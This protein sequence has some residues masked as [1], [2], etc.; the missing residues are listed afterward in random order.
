MRCLVI[1]VLSA[2]IL[3]GIFISNPQGSGLYSIRR[4]APLIEPAATSLRPAEPPPRTQTSERGSMQIVQEITPLERDKPIERE[5][6]GGQSHS[7]RITM[8]SGQ[9]LQVAVDQR[10]VDVLVTLF[11]PDGE[12]RIEVDSPTGTA[13]SEILSTIAAAAGTYRIEVSALDKTVAI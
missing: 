6:S 9:Y 2:S 10:G 11:A 4:P 12:K 3:P 5:L 8:I 1:Y 7:Y 13:E